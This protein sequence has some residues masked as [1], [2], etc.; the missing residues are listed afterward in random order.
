LKQGSVTPRSFVAGKDRLGNQV[1]RTAVECEG[2]LATE[3]K[4]KGWTR[5]KA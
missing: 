3:S 5:C 1:G 2:A 4:V